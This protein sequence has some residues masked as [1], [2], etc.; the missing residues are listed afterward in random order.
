[1]VTDTVKT[2]SPKEVMETNRQVILTTVKASL[3]NR[4][5]VI[6]G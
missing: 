4:I 5:A 6:P 1:M 2:R 3:N